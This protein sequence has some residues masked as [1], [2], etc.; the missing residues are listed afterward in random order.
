VNEQPL[1]LDKLSVRYGQLQAVDNISLELRA[2]KILTLIGPNGCGKST[3]TKAIAGIT[4]YCGEVHSSKKLAYLPQQDSLMPWLN[5][6]DNILLPATIK[7]SKV[8]PLIK[9]ANSYLDKFEL[10]QFA[11]HY[12]H[13]LSGGMRQKVALIRTVLYQPELVL[14]DEPFSALDSITRL[15]MQN[16]LLELKKQEDFA[17]LLI[18]HDISEAINVSDNI[19]ALSKRPATIVEQFKVNDSI[20]KNPVKKAELEQSLKGILINEKI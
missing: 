3:I 15:E 6:T 7:S 12:P 9:K 5:V 1:K 18:T 10:S 11:K 17:C 8:Q 2:N 14:I 20:R 4:E 19:I 16:W 13:Q